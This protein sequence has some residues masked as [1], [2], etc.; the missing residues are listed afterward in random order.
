MPRAEMLLKISEIVL[1]K[2]PLLLEF[3]SSLLHQLLIIIFHN[4]HFIIY[5]M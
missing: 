4:L 2:L 1:G 5:E 3:K